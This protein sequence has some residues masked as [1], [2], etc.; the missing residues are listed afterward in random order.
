MIGV[1]LFL[2][3]CWTGPDAWSLGHVFRVFL[4]GI[5]FAFFTYK[6]KKAWTPPTGSGAIVINK[7]AGNVF[8]GCAV[9]QL[10]ITPAQKKSSEPS[11]AVFRANHEL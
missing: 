8:S 2:I 5:S 10:E 4:G 6:P 3:A 7:A 11:M 1:V 9:E